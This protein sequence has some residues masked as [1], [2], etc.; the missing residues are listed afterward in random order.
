MVDNC[1]IMKT[2]EP[3][4]TSPEKGNNTFL[5]V[6]KKAFIFG[7]GLFLGAESV[8]F[9]KGHLSGAG[10]TLAGNAEIPLTPENLL[11]V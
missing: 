3:N 10:N 5:N 9:L 11:E 7:V 6:F 1:L 8:L 2:Q 4:I